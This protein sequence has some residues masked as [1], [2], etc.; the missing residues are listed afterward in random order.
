MVRDLL[1]GVCV[2]CATLGGSMAA[3]KLA[4]NAT[5]PSHEPVEKIES[6]RIESLSVPV[7]RNGK[8]SGYVL[9]SI[10]A[11]VPASVMK[12]QRDTLSAYL[13]EAAFRTLYNEPAFDFAMLKPAD[14]EQL[15]G[16]IMAGVNN[17]LGAGGVKELLIENLNFVTLEEIRNAQ[18]RS[19]RADKPAGN[20][21]PK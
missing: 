2:V 10:V 5:G 8:V 4:G 6:L 14:T 7:L 16:K 9:A 3:T 1:L 17:R 18:A 12:E 21:H 11:M 13:N 19:K 15:S 20:P